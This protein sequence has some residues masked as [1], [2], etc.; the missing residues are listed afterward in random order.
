MANADSV[1]ATRAFGLFYKAFNASNALPADT[2]AWGT[3]PTGFTDVGYTDGGLNFGVDETRNEIR[4][5]QEFN[6]VSNPI[7][8]VTITMGTDLAEM[9]PANIQAATGLGT[10]TT[11]AAASGTR[12]HDQLDINSS[13]SDDFRTWLGRV[14]QPDG[15]VFN[16]SLWKSIAT[17]ALATTF[18]AD[19]KATIAMEVTGLA[20]TS[21]NPARIA[22]VRDV[23]PALP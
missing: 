13:F 16:I 19:D 10:L 3:L 21:T 23:L 22:T 14:K 4:V 5:D 17:G 9:T 18:N 15:E 8:E 1:I 20:D 6:P 7:S 12:G 2:V 11:V